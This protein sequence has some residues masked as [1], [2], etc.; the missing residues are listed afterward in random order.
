M[1]FKFKKLLV[2]SLSVMLLASTFTQI[3]HAARDDDWIYIRKE[4]PCANYDKMKNRSASDFKGGSNGDF[5]TPGSQANKVAHAIFDTLTEDWGFSSAAAI[6]VLANCNHESGFIPNRAE[7]PSQYNVPYTGSDAVPS[8]NSNYKAFGMNSDAPVENMGYYADRVPPFLGGGGLFQFTPFTKFTES[9]R[10][11][12]HGDGWD[13]V[14]Q[15]AFLMDEFAN[16][17]LLVGGGIESTVKAAGQQVCSSAEDFFGTDSPEK[18]ASSFYAWYERGA[19]A[20]SR[21]I[22]ARKVWDSGEF[23]TSRDGDPSKWP[24]VGSGQSKKIDASG[25][26]KNKAKEECKGEKINLS[27]EF[28]QRCVELALARVGG[29][30]VWGGNTWGSTYS[31]AGMDCSGFVM[32]VLKRAGLKTAIPRTAADQGLQYEKWGWQVDKENAVAGDIVVFSKAGPIG[33]AEHIGWYGGTN[34]KYPN[35]FFIH[36]SNP[37]DGIIISSATYY[38]GSLYFFHPEETPEVEFGEPDMSDTDEL[39]DFDTAF[40]RGGVSW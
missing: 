9:K 29:T 3:S 13:P 24:D 6:G 25:A 15:V 7:E 27:S 22:E 34:E 14:N 5:L 21:D 36:A 31:D 8:A 37:K 16:G 4:D 35:G 33:S 26:M 30:Y 28:N 20:Q 39:V 12:E 11:G 18:A 19:G 2:L 10:F 1:R 17:D 32:E 23:D 38:T 40:E